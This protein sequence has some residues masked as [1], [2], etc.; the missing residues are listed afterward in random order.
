MKQ[1]ACTEAIL[2]YG[3]LKY[4]NHR[5]HRTTHTRKKGAGF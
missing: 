4:L 2:V 1:S 5:P 3:S